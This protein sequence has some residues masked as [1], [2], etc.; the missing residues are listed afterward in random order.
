MT[1]QQKAVWDLKQQGLKQSEIADRLGISLRTVSTRVKELREAPME[2]GVQEAMDRFG[3]TK[4]PKSIWF[5]DDTLSVQLYPDQGTEATFLEQVRDA[6]DGIPLAPDIPL[7]TP[8]NSNTMVVYPLF[9]AHLGM[10]AHAEI[11]GEEIDLEKGAARIIQGVS[12]VMAGAPNSERAVF[13][14]G[15]DFTHQTD[16]NN[17]TRRSGHV[18]DVDGRNIVTVIEAIEVIC[19]CIDM[20]LT[21]HQTVEYHSVPGNHDP[22]N[23]ETI[24]IGLANRYRDHDRVHINFNITEF[25][26]VEHGE[27]VIFVHHGD[28]RTPKDLAMFCAAEYPEVWGRT[29]YRIVMTGHL[30]HLK[31][32]EFPGIYWMQVPAI[33][34]RDAH[35]AGGYNSHSMIMAIGFDQKS[36]ITRNMVKL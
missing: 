3:L 9:D 13:I 20:A 4:I 25:S 14:N 12:H 8:V 11:S 19:A 34:V 29:R 10:R 21:K 17:R 35:A 26:V 15:G 24:L 18:L 6:L 28:K 1:D 5:K 36:E 27:V 22:Q 31:V 30:H 33:T 16:D 2:A 23:W 7:Q 32:D